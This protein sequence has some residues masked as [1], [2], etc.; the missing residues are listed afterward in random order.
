M[1]AEPQTWPGSAVSLNACPMAQRIT[2]ARALV[3]DPR[4]LVFDE[5]T[6]ALD[7]ETEALVVS[8]IER[9]RVGRTTLVIAHRLST[10]QR[11]DHVLVLEAGRLVERGT[12]ASLRDAGGLFSRLH[13]HALFT[14]ES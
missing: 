9:A 14:V 10:V 13:Q 4:I 2:I 7:P 3:R 8:G 1:C 5:P 11:A 6:S 12:F